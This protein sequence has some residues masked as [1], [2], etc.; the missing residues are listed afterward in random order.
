MKHLLLA[1]AALFAIAKPA[2][3]SDCEALVA[4]IVNRTGLEVVRFRGM[5]EA[6]LKDGDLGVRLGCR[7]RSA[8]IEAQSAIPPRRFFELAGELGNILTGAAAGD[9]RKAAEQCQRR[10]LQGRG[11]AMEETRHAHLDCLFMRG[12][13][14]YVLIL[15]RR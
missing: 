3:A 2:A 14:S 9:I 12:A 4:T 10:A 6:Q 7:D 1:V 5:F 15:P 8:N 11:A 13:S